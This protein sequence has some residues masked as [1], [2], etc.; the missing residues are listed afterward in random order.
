[1]KACGAGT[2]GGG[3]R[4]SRDVSGLDDEGFVFG[5]AGLLICFLLQPLKL[6]TTVLHR[7]A[8]H[9]FGHPG[10]HYYHHVKA[11]GT[12]LLLWVDGYLVKALTASKVAGM[13]WPFSVHFTRPSISGC[14]CGAFAEIS[15]CTS[16]SMRRHSETLFGNTLSTLYKV[17]DTNRCLTRFLQAKP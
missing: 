5:K 2:G 15:C 8:G 6:C 4:R 17:F 9:L 12:G 7:K 16:G 3:C 1:M 11:C 10:K 14:R 13:T